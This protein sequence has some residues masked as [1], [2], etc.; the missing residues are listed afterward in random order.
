MIHISVTHC[1]FWGSVPGLLG[2]VPKPTGVIISSFRLSLLPCCLF[3]SLLPV[4]K[5]HL[6]CM[7]VF[8]KKCHRHHRHHR[9]Q[10]VKQMRETSII[11]GV[12]RWLFF[13]RTKMETCTFCNGLSLPLI[14]LVSLRL[15]AVCLQKY[16]RCVDSETECRLRMYL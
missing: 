16:W 12:S 9:R 15:Y 8:W 14:S 13:V 7:F 1:I 10:I 4:M 6:V 3:I 11:Y 5:W 2:S